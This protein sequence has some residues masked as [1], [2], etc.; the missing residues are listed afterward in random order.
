MVNRAKKIQI[1]I[2]DYL[3]DGEEVQAKIELVAAKMEALGNLM[4]DLQELKSH[5]EYIIP[6]EQVLNEK[7]I[8]AG[9]EV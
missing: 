3:E 2:Q 6:D 4:A 7:L 9:V 1:N 8:A 5:T